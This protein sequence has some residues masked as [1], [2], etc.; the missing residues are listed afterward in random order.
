MAMNMM[1]QAWA[2]GTPTI[3]TGCSPSPLE[4][5]RLGSEGYDWAWLDMQH[6]TH[7]YETLLWL[8]QALELGGTRALV[9]ASWNEPAAIMRPLDYGAIGVIIPMVGSA[10]EAE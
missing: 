7:D 8:I 10:T 5:E 3:G 1:R 2:A 6:G 9:R 4:A